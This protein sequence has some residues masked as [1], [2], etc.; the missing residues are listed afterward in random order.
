VGD[1]LDLDAI[2]V[3]AHKNVVTSREALSLIAALRR[4]T[5]RAEKAESER[6][7]A[8]TALAL[9]HDDR[10]SWKARALAAEEAYEKAAAE[11]ARLSA[12]HVEDRIAACF[13]GVTADA[14]MSTCGTID[15]WGVGSDDRR[16]HDALE[17]VA[18]A[19]RDRERSAREGGA[20]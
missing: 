12:P 7:D 20:K 15:Y 3:F 11:A 17:S 9:M 1:D 10:D 2:E 13:D 4:E 6:E 14:I 19:L 16:V 18:A 8:N 5:E